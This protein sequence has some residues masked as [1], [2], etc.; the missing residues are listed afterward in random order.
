MNLI[1]YDIGLLILFVLLVGIFLYR[2]RKK[3]Q[4]QGL[5][6]LYRTHWG[7]KFIDKIGK[8]YKRL[9]NWLSYVSIGIGYLLM[10]GIIY[11]VGKIVY[12][13]VL[14]QD[15]V[16]AIK[17]PPIT[18]LFPYIDRVVPNLGLP[19]FYFIYFI[20]IIALI[21]IPHE[22][23]HGI[24]MRR[25]NIKIKKTGFGFFPFFL[26][27]FLAAFVEQDEK[28]M[29]KSKKFHQMAVLSAGTFANI[30]TAIFFFIIMWLFFSLSF[31]PTGLAFDTYAYD[32]VTIENIAIVNGLAITNINY[33]GFVSLINEEGLNK[34][35]TLDG[36]KYVINK[37]FLDNLEEEYEEMGMYYDAPA[38]NVGLEGA[39]TSIN[40]APITSLEVF[41]NELRKY[42]PGDNVTIKTIVNEETKSYEIELVEN[43]EGGEGGY[44]GVGFF[45]TGRSGVMGRVI[46]FMSSFKSSSIYYKAK[47]NAAWFIYNLLWW[48]VLISLTVALV[49]M[50]PV[51]IFD[52]GRF[53]YL[54]VL[55]I[56]KSK[57]KAEKSFKFVTK[58]FLFLLLVLMV[59]WVKSLLF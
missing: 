35:E 32:I 33:S 42:L 47:F 53:F 9:L 4:R 26:P 3:I 27:I 36:K 25:Y 28:S 19:S 20:I 21:A 54:T 41:Q 43:P 13:Y 24:F 18:P 31:A 46:D 49:N 6:I 38:I 16:R 15:I 55:A 5:L 48:L 22:F 30:L 39:I 29:N 17:I 59:F 7:I 40:K 34:I 8:K 45:D 58:L 52:G 10:A 12:I 56:T 11:L 50:L 14:R 57:K 2:N 1:I 51:G 37:E 23:F 44:L